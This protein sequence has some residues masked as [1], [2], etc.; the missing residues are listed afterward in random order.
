MIRKQYVSSV[1]VKQL[2]TVENNVDDAKINPLIFK[3]QDMHIQPILG[4]DFHNHLQEGIENDTL[5]Q[6]E[7]DLIN[8]YIKPALV[9][10]THYIAITQLANKTTNK[11]VANEFSQYTINAERASQK[12]LKNELRDSAEFYTKRLANFLCLNSD[13]FP[14]YENP[15]DKENLHK[16]SKSYFSGIYIPRRGVNNKYTQYKK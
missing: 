2:T 15:T 10:W 12:D 5:T 16:N 11:T 14:L 13:L 4:S 1:E 6:D 8:D 3:A 7:K 9:D